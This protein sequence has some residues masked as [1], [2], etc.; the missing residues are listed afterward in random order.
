[1]RMGGNGPH[2]GLVLTQGSMASYGQVGYTRSDS[3]NRGKF[4]FNNDAMTL[5]ADESYTVSW[6]IFAHD[7]EKD[8]YQKLDAQTDFVRLESDYYTK[9]MDKG[10][11]FSIT[12]V[13][14]LDLTEAT[15]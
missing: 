6:K 3:N 4:I 15:L 9:E 13:S 5:E 14:G 10:E 12:A 8:F 11:A 1:M 2:V 7:G